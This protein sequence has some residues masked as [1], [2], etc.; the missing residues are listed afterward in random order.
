V[1]A[2][3]RVLA[4]VTVKADVFTEFV[5]AAVEPIEREPNVTVPEY[6]KSRV[7]PALRFTAPVPVELALAAASVPA[8]IVV[9]PLYLLL[10]DKMT[11]PV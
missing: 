3:L 1:I 5:M 10:P 6:C 2:L 11:V 7:L 4:P 8:V 9:P